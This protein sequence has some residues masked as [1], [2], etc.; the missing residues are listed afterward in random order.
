RIADTTGQLARSG[1]IRFDVPF[2]FG[3]IPAGKYRNLR[4]ASAT[5]ALDACFALGNTLGSEISALP[6]AN[7]VKNSEFTTALTHALTAVQAKAGEVE[8]AIGHP[9]DP[10]YR[11]PAKEKGWLRIRLA[12]P[13]T[14]KH[15]APRLRIATFNIAPATNAITVT[16]ELAGS[17]D[18]RPGQI[19]TL[20]N[21]NVLDGTLE[22]A[23]QEEPDQPLVTWRAVDSLDAATP[24]DRVFALD[25]EAGTITFG[26]GIRGRIPA[27]VPRGGGIVAVRYRFGGGKAG[28]S[29]VAT[30][31]SLETARAGLAGVT[32]PVVATG[33]ADAETLDEAKIR[34]RQELSTRSRAVTRDDFEWI[35]RQT[36]TVRVARAQI[37]PRRRPLPAG[38][39]PPAI[40]TPVCGAPL[41]A[42]PAGLDT[43]EAAGV[44][45][46]VVV[47]DDEGAEPV[48]TP[49]FLR[50]VCCH[51]DKYR[52]VTTEVHVVPPQ[53][54]R[55]CEVVITL[56]PQP[57]FTRS[58]LQ[59]LVEARLAAYLHVLTGGH[60]GTGYP[61]GG[62]VHVADLI[63]QV[64][65]VEG[66]ERVESLAARFTHTKSNVALRQGR[67]T[68]CPS[69]T[70]E[71]DEVQLGPEE[72]V[73]LMPGS[74]TVSTVV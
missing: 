44:V 50:R 38:T 16:N 13:L 55:I 70:D 3:P 30:I 46:V 54:L 52:L 20:G 26:D 67:L 18:G 29:G 10:K 48:P 37:V 7:P 4:D 33:G 39:L 12:A 66:V 35:A 60:A 65:R 63:A 68:L 47:P 1:T 24:N 41:P 9:L 31:T 11:D 17:A 57:G 43:I 64:F 34:A 8:P 56:L 49:S 21:G 72:S 28:E 40:A 61:F 42:G 62:Q 25:R 23:V 74:V 15:A 71:T 51:L 32:N 69:T 2:T 73:S 53:Y 59:A 19:V 22:L 45:S 5:T 36:P 58:R 27:L 14:T 6:V